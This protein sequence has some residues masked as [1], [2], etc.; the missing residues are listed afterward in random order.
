MRIISLLST[1]ALLATTALSAQA[2][3]VLKSPEPIYPSGARAA[4]VAGVIDVDVALKADGSVESVLPMPDTVHWK[5]LFPSA[6]L[7]AE[8]W[9]FAPGTKSPVRI[10]FVF[11]LY[12]EGTPASKL[13]AEFL[14]PQTMIIK[15]TVA[16]VER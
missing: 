5:L 8:K 12:P 14:N 13:Q 15:S 3:V 2:V 10:T 1:P 11:H 6:S 16:F 4:Q 9:V 7:A